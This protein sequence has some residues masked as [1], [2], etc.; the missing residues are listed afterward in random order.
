MRAS[1][2]VN[3]I[4]TPLLFVWIWSNRK[5]RMLFNFIRFQFEVVFC[6]IF[7]LSLPEKSIRIRFVFSSEK[8]QWRM[9]KNSIQ[10]KHSNRWCRLITIVKCAKCKFRSSFLFF[11]SLDKNRLETSYRT[12]N[13]TSCN[14]LFG[15]RLKLFLY[16]FS[17]LASSKSFTFINKLKTFFSSF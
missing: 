10:R 16:L 6:L 4:V 3:G 9:R 8:W 15:S 5:R 2:W 14:R 11:V 17:L 1:R 7:S 13:D 12:W